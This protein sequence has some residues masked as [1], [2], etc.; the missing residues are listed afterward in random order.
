MALTRDDVINVALLARL[1]LSERELDFMTV[2][3]DQIVEYVRQLGELDTS[4]VEPMAH[5]LDVVNVFRPDAVTPSMDRDAILA[6]APKADGEF[7][8]VPTVL[9]L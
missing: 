8:L 2:Q 3:L 9:G 4:N 5:A 6:N 1:A 7:Y